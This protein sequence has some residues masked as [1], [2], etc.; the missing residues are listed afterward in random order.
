MSIFSLTSI[1]VLVLVMAVNSASAWL[2]NILLDIDNHPCQPRNLK[3]GQIKVTSYYYEKV[4]CRTS[5]GTC[6]IKRATFFVSTDGGIQIIILPVIGGHAPF[7]FAT[8]N[9]SMGNVKHQIVALA[10]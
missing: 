4:H 5:N 9:V 8:L 10:K 6:V 1:K 7:Q 2:K 3:V